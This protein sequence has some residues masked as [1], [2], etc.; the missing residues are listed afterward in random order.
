M[1]VA[2]LKKVKVIASILILLAGA[3]YG[4]DKWVDAKIASHPVIIIDGKY[5]DDNENEIMKTKEAVMELDDQVTDLE[6]R[7]AKLKLQIDELLI[8]GY[9][10]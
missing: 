4:V 2:E 6:L 10:P 9:Y 5:I 3:L 1:K 7:V 8:K